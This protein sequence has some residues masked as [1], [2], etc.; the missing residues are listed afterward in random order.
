MVW[1]PVTF[2][3][4]LTVVMQVELPQALVIVHVMVEVPVLN[5]PLA[6]FPMPFLVVAPVIWNEIFKLPLQLLE[7]INE[8]IV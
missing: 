6:S 7:A 3:L 5:T 1:V 8:G 2:G 4:T